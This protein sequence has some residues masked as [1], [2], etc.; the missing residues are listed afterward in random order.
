[1][2]IKLTSIFVYDQEEALKFYTEVLG[3]EKKNDFP[4]GETRWLT[5]VSSGEPEGTELV[6]EPG[7]NPAARAFKK[8]IFE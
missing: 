4:V 1:M 7:D 2:K 3:F 5:V 8:T 6:L